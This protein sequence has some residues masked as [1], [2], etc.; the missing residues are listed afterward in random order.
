M[1][2]SAVLVR[3]HVDTWSFVLLQMTRSSG[4]I[5][6][7][8]ARWSEDQSDTR[9]WVDEELKLMDVKLSGPR[10][11][12]VVQMLWYLPNERRGWGRPAGLVSK[13]FVVV[14]GVDSQKAQRIYDA[15]APVI[16]RVEVNSPRRSELPTVIIDD[17]I[18]STS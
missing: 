12:D 1:G 7:P 3:C 6:T 16:E 18:G 8:A 15:I 5:L 14:T 4:G 13:E 9:T 11:A 2:L 10:L 17:A